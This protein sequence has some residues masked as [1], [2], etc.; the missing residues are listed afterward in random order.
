MNAA[1]SPTAALRCRSLQN[2]R[3]RHALLLERRQA[4]RKD[5]FADQRYRLAE[6][7]RADDR[8]LAGAL[9]AGGVENLI[10]QRLAVLVLLGED[11]AGDLDQVAVQLAL[12]PLGEDLVQLIGGQAQAVAAAGRRPRRSAACRRTRCRCAPS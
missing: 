4:A 9:L 12:V 3:R 7:E 11:V 1:R 8:P 6:I 5:R 2:L 10:D